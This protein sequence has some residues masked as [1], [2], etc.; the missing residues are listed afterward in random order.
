MDVRLS[1]R[2]P[3]LARLRAGFAAGVTRPLAWRQGQLAALEA[4][5]HERE[6]E[7]ARA[8]AEDLGKPDIE[9]LTHES[10]YVARHARH[11]R[12]HLAG[13]A[14]PRRM[15][16]DLYNRPG[17]ARLVPEPR[18]PVL[19]LAP[20]N[21]PWHLALMPL[22][23]ALAAGNPALVKPSEL[24]PA[25]SALLAELVP[26]YLDPE[27][28][29]VV[30]GGAT[31]AEALLAEP[32]GLVF[33]TGS[34]AVGRKVAEAAGRTLSPVVLELGGRNPTVVAPD[35]DLELAA[36]RIAWGKLLNAGQTCVAPDH[37]LIER[38]SVEAFVAAY[39][40]SVRR[41][42]GKDPQ[43]SPDYG[44]IV[45]RAH[46]D[47]LA[48]LLKEGHIAHGGRHDG[49]D[50]FV[51]PTALTRLPEGARVLEEEVFGPI[52]PIVEVDSIDDA[53]ARINAGPKP[54]AV[55]LFSS[56]PAIRRRVIDETSSGAVVLNDVV[57]HLSSPDLPFGGIGESGFGA[58]H[59]KAGFDTFS[60]LKP[61][62]ERAAWIDP[63]LRYPPYSAR[64]RRWL[65]RIV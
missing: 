49:D 58:Y 60:H 64:K 14:R 62:L 32:W 48:R 9:A 50:L 29:Q 21:Y 63:P 39:R 52:L 15:P 2:A 59:G 7:I 6:G 61:V 28:V 33:F 23:G 1:R 16:V 26:A 11:T 45:S 24:A 65:R 44:R 38:G 42:L 41:M 53:I 4:M 40:R 36:R 46:F 22:I 5:C 31:L 25:T 18:G 19:I 37:V 30:E 56:D 17:R 34:T 10:A 12:R 35:A 51:E 20:W 27:A 3:D 8:L 57:I 47:R 54:L 55:Y 13:W 43:A